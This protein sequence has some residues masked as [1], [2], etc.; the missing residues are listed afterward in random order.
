M[1]SNFLEQAVIYLTAAIVCVPIAKKLG[2]GSVLGYLLA[3][4][5][6]GPFLLGFI[7]D[8]GK[9][10]MHFAEFG[11]VMMLFLIGLEL[12]PAHFWKMRK[13][14]VGMGS[15]QL[16]GTIA[17]LFVLGL[18]LHF[19]WQTSL[20][21]AMA[22]AMSSTAIVLQSLKEKGLMQSEV[23][24][25]S[26]AVLLFQDIAV[27]PILAIL[28]LLAFKKVVANEQHGLLDS[29][30]A[31]MHT[32]AVL[33]A[34]GI[35]I[36]MGRYIIVPL[37]RLIAKTHLRELFTASA[38]L[39]VLFIAYL[40]E[41]VGL[42]PALGT[43]LAGVVLANSEY[44]HELE[45]DLDP[46]KGLLLGLFFVA[47]GASIDFQ[48]IAENTLQLV[49]LVSGI[50]L[51]KF[52]VL[53]GIGKLFKIKLNANLL[54]SLGL[55]QV[56]EFAFVLFSF[57]NQLTILDEHWMNLMMAVTAISMTLTP[58]MLLI[59]EK[60]IV[61]KLNSPTENESLNSHQNIN[62]RHK[63]MIVGFSHFGSTIGRFLRANGV[64]ATILDNDSDN[65][66]LLRKMGFKVYYGDA[67]RVELLQSAGAETAEILIIAIDD[68]ETTLIVADMAKRNFPNLEI[69]IRAKNRS[70]AYEIMDLGLRNIY[71]ESIDTSVRLGVDVLKKIG[72]RS[73]TATR[74]GQDFL[75]YD[76]AAMWELAKS[77]HNMKQYISDVREQIE[78]QE[79]ILK[80][81]FQNTPNH[82]DHAWDTDF[83]KESVTKK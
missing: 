74:S 60:V 43:F 8:E 69:M 64:E 22:L 18:T 41:L 79:T 48:L 28:P 80:R 38:L 15:I 51:T 49:L 4:I 21:C 30:P 27:I 11:V 23:G 56:G 76:E 31:W 35:V 3:G 72:F 67:T 63:I 13:T 7:G 50:M 75:K 77:R 68:P 61:K 70:D 83:I 32:L 45:S 17:I 26:F 10:I 47:V 57:I 59:Y 19:E 82:Q 24:S 20:A 34:V 62:E 46:F 78:I 6:I 81:D 37:L 1:G 71:R 42:S 54:F 40:M 14:I 52:L 65:V 25:S 29:I 33:M 58:L 12:E 44:R 73:Y 36:L 16:L 5:I 39:I 2:L 53:L 55:A 66:D 9:D